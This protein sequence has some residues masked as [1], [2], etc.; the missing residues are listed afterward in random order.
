M[1]HRLIGSFQA[2]GFFHFHHADAA[3]F[4]G[5]FHKQGQAQLTLDGGKIAVVMQHGKFGHGQ[6]QTLPHQLGAV[7]VHADGAGH[8]AAAGVGH[9]Q[10]FEQ[11]LHG[12]VFAV[13]AVQRVEGR[14]KTERLQL[15]DILRFGVKRV[16]IN[17]AA[18]QSRHNGRAA[19][20]RY[21][22]LAGKSA[23]QDGHFA[24]ILHAVFFSS[25]SDGLFVQTA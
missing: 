19:V 24:E 12:A 4:Y 25:V 17:A 8:H 5:R 9:T 7:F 21:V 3:A 2:A 13:S 11:A 23:H 18:L 15:H 14:L 10:G 16:R 6:A 22:A 20:E 1:F